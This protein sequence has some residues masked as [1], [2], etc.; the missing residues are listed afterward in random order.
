MFFKI[1][2]ALLLGMGAIIAPITGSVLEMPEVDI[3]QYA[4]CVDLRWKDTDM[5]NGFIDQWGYCIPGHVSNESWFMKQ[6]DLIYGKAVFYSPGIMQSTAKYRGMSYPEGYLGGV[7]LGSPGEI[8]ET[9]WL[10]GPDGWEGPYLVVDCPQRVD[11]FTTVV[12]RQQS[13]EV[14]FKTAMR[15]GMVAWNDP[16][17]LSKGWYVNNWTLSNIQVYKGLL[18]PADI[19][20][21]EPVYFADWW[22][23]RVEFADKHEPRPLMQ[24]N[25]NHP[26]WKLE[27]T[28]EEDWQCFSCP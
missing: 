7:A 12:I 28:R 13:V 5:T 21:R 18:L 26:L 3:A 19:N 10:N 24:E 17:D 6:P 16:T 15:W 9:V 20:N 2:I 8:G 11:V 22:L 25:G 27:G 23:E 4:D 14:D 1:V